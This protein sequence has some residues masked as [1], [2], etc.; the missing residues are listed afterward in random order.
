MYH[1]PRM[2][3][4]SNDS[5]FGLTVRGPAIAGRRD[6]RVVCSVACEVALEAGCSVVVEGDGCCALP[7]GGA[8]TAIVRSIR[9]A[10]NHRLQL[11]VIVIGNLLMKTGS[12]GPTQPGHHRRYTSLTNKKT[13]LPY[14]VSV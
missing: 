11:P 12:A 14:N 1:L 9:P 5:G 7:Y 2:G 3:P 13:R 8:P 6:G 10:T 4:T